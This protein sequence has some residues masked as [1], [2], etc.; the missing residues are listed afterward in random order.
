VRGQLRRDHPAPYPV[1]I[2]RRLIRMY[3]FVGDTVVDPFGGTGTTAVAALEV[4]RNSVSVEIEP[5]YIEQIRARLK[6]LSSL[7]AQIEFHS[8]QISLAKTRTA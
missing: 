1:E 4:G 3:S 2:A 6:G 5:T 7:T 8:N